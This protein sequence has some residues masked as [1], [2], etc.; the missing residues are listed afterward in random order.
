MPLDDAEW[1]DRQLILSGG[2]TAALEK[3]IH[4]VEYPDVGALLATV[5]VKPVRYGDFKTA[6]PL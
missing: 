3:Q 2:V 4:R 6:F 1:R 5:S